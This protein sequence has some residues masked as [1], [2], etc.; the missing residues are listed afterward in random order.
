MKRTIFIITGVVCLVVPWVSRETAVYGAPI[1]L[2]LGIVLALANCSTYPKEAKKFSRVL[3]QSAIV[4]MGLS[5][6]LRQVVAAGASG[7]LFAAGT[8]AGTF[9]L[10]YVLSRVLDVERVLATLLSSGTAIC[11]GSAI[12]ATGSVIRAGDGPMSVAL[13]CVFVLNAVAL[14]AF[15][16]IGHALDLTAHQFGAWA[17][18][19]IHDVSSVVGAAQQY[20]EDAAQTKIAVDEATVIKLVRT[21]WIVPVSIGCAWVLKRGPFER[22]EEFSH[23]AQE[24]G[25]GKKKKKLFAASPVP[26]FIVLFV[27]AAAV[28]TVLPQIDPVAHVLRDIAKNTLMVLA[29]FLIG[30]GLSR[31]AIASVGWR[32]FVLAIG[33]WIA[34]AGVSLAVIVKTV[35]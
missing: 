19:A 4:L 32:P 33:L 28:R 10:G 1:G 5:I 7:F 30:S 2:T 6:D 25:A 18:V 17:A 34:I 31:K 8:I 15:P 3:I 24:G 9:A 27:V 35:H 23:A 14:Y 26:W 21:L 22:K 11:G 16:P 20:S 12:A 29:L 13:A